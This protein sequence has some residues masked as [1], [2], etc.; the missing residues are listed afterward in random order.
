MYHFIILLLSILALAL[1]SYIYSK[2]SEYYAGN[3]TI[4]ELNTLKPITYPPY[5][6]TC[7][8]AAPPYVDWCMY[9]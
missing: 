5:E 1:A 9:G 7:Q 8:F 6:Y 4:S 2:S 3:V